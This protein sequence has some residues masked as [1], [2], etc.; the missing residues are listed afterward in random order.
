MEEAELFAGSI[1]PVFEGR[2]PERLEAQPDAKGL[3]TL[4]VRNEAM[5]THYINHL[6]LVE[7]THAPGETVV[8]DAEGL[9]IVVKDLRAPDRVVNRGG[10]DLIATLGAADGDCYATG[11][12]ALKHPTAS[13][14]DDSIDLSL[15]VSAGRG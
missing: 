10:R 9:P 8:P 4:E 14:M 15:T 7:V 2:D 12:Q 11:P 6:Q 5:E 3:I 1:A 13:A